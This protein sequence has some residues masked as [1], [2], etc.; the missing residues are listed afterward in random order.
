MRTDLAEPSGPE[1][2]GSAS[3]TARPMGT[4]PSRR[5]GRDLWRDGAMVLSVVALLYLCALPLLFLLFGSTNTGSP[6]QVGTFSLDKFAEVLSAGRTYRLIGVSVVYAAGAALISFSLGG[7]LTWLV[8]R[9]DLP[10][11]GVF[12][13]IVLFPL[14]MPA[15]LI[16][17]SW[18]LLL[19]ENIG[20]INR[21]LQNSLG[22]ADAP[23][24]VHTLFG[25]IWVRGLMDV[26]LVFLWLWPAFSAMDPSLEE[27]AAMSRAGR[28]QT[29]R[30]ITLPLM[31]PALLATFLISF[32]LTLEDVTVPI[33]IG[34][35][36]GINV[37]ASEIYLATSRAPTDVNGASVYAVLLLAITLVLTIIYRRLT[38]QTEQFVIIRG[39]G[40]RPQP[41][42]LGRARIPMTIFVA[43]SLLVIVGL[44]LFVLAW[45]SLS[46]FLQVP[47][48]NG[49]RNLSFRWYQILAVD[50]EALRGFINSALL[51]VISSAIVM[52]LAV[53]VGWI[54]IRSRSRV[55]EG[56]DFLAFLP[57]SVPGLVIGLSL[58]W[59]YLSL[60][61]PIYGTFWI[62]VIAYVTRFI[63]YG[64]RLTYAGFAQLHKELEEAAY[65]A[66]SG[67]GKTLTTISLPLLAPTLTVGMI[68][69]FLRAFR[70]LPASLL[71]ASFGNEPY[72][73]VS[74]HM[75]SAGEPGKTA[76]YGIVALLVVAAIVF[77]V[78]KLTRRRLFLE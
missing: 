39:R 14:F 31:L 45:T 15:V 18:I 36:A 65:V 43:F 4:A 28:F 7:L 16:S 53:I 68:Y 30:T 24:N 60:P 23:F 41:V 62:L 63:P 32:V 75:W 38:Y 10:G 61:L 78:Q 57:I 2:A 3:L 5:K 20:L 9:T 52:A 12:T 77:T 71:L 22:L 59:L 76:G 66:G 34:L 17:I 8:Q 33:F 74:Y 42:P 1:S 44:P 55:R 26:P 56:L 29:I 6:G 67:W 19:D 11:K 35:T 48:M 51:G 21:V 70:E 46:R 47:S 37:F 73:V 64:V 69:I 27:A 49:L 13:F 58:M 50:P 25:M 40:Y 54:V 72:S